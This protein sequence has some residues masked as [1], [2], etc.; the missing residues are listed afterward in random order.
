MS[1]LVTGCA[2]FIGFNVVK[3]LLNRGDKVIGVDNINEYYDPQLKKDRLQQLNNNKHSELFT[4]YKSDLSKKKEVEKIFKVAEFHKVI[5]LA[6]T[7][8]VRYSLENPLSYVENNITAFINILEACRY[9]SIMHL[10]YASTSSVYGA[11]T[12]LPYKSEKSADHPLQFYAATKRA[13]ELM[14][15]SY[16]HLFNLPTTGLRFF[17]VY[18]PWT[19]PDMALFIFTKNIL[20]KKEIQIFNNGDQTRDFTYVD[21]IADAVIKANDKAATSNKNW[22]SYTPASDS[23]NAP[24]RIYNIGNSEAINLMQY[25]EL[26]EEHTKIKAIKNFHDAQP[27]DV[28]NTLSDN[29]KFIKDIGTI[30][31]TEINDGVK[32]FVNWYKEY[33]GYEK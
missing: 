12:N 16:S 29:S 7:P 19:R 17:T 6:A 24:Y 30:K 9:S 31:K 33:Y 23:S 25:I 10:T 4:F 18:G 32:N 1:I 20:E 8:G 28:V 5:H 27:G 3:L 15:H 22:N 14:A 26:I 11:N 21:D 13:N 2:G